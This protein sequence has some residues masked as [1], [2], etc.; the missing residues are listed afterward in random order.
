MKS[1]RSTLRCST[2]S[3][4]PFPFLFPWISAIKQEFIL[5]WYTCAENEEGKTMR[6]WEGAEKAGKGMRHDGTAKEASYVAEAD[7]RRCRFGS[8]SSS[9]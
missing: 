1:F 2:K 9:S 6:P 8:S 4:E 7:G 5:I 3:P